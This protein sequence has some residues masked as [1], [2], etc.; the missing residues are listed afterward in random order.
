MPDPLLTPPEDHQRN[1]GANRNAPAARLERQSGSEAGARGN[2]YR[3]GSGSGYGSESSYGYGHGVRP[4]TT[5]LNRSLRDYIHW[6]LRYFWVICITTLLGLFYG[7]YD[8]SITP[9]VYQSS[10]VIEVKRLQREAADI[11]EDSKLQLGGAGAIADLIEKLQMPTLFDSVARSS[12]FTNRAEAVP[13]TKEWVMPWRA[14]SPKENPAGEKPAAPLPPEYLAGMMR[15][16]VSVRWRTQTTLVDLSANHSVPEVA[17]DTLQSL[18]IEYERLSQENIGKSESYTFDYILEQSDGIKNQILSIE[19]SLN[20]YS[21]C[22]ELNTRIAQSEQNLLQLETRYLARWPKIIE[23]NQLL[24]ILKERF[25]QE[26]AKVLEAS[27]EERQFWQDNFTVVAGAPEADRIEAQQK[28]VDARY[29][30]LRK[31]LQTEETILQNLTM[32]LKEGDVSRGFLAKQ[33]EV[34]QPPTLPSWAS[35]PNKSAILKKFTTFGLGFGILAVF[36]LGL[37]DPSIRTV[38]DLETLT[39]IPVVGALPLKLGEKRTRNEKAQR[40]LVLVETPNSQ[41]AESIR[42]LR[43]G[44]TYLGDNTERKTFLVTSALASEGKSWVAAN[45]AVAFAQQGDRTLVIDA[46]L[47]RA[48]L[49][50]IFNVPAKKAGL[51]DLLTRKVALKDAVLPT[52]VENLYFLSAG[53]R[54]PNPAEMLTSRNLEALISHLETFFDRIIFDSAPLVLVSD[55]LSIAKLVQSV[56]VVYHLGKTPRRALFRALKYLDANHSSPAGLIANQLPSTKTRHAYGYYYS[57][58]SGG[59]YGGSYGGYE[60]VTEAEADTA[61]EEIPFIVDEAPPLTRSENPGTA[62]GASSPFPGNSGGASAREP[63]S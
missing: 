3:S 55:S 1:P 12:L 19:K 53:T 5:L 63:Q 24:S 27:P 14:F 30:L 29:N 39:M 9:P 49:H 61:E 10:A 33:F 6:F 48:V 8:F 17:R 13:R 56:L 35:A 40:D 42:T 54:S 38:A 47:R 58:A 25:S 11:D 2:H 20:R 44:L 31:E 43:A 41:Q 26:L 36:I 62:P 7:F 46:D 4:G 22:V 18:L 50:H 45:L 21:Q 51:S 28:T 23:A 15:N 34:V 16:W 52:S 57:Y 37:L 32:K 59:G 60:A